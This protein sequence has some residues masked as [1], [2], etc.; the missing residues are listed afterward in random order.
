MGDKTVGNQVVGV[1][2]IPIQRSALED[3][4]EW[5]WFNQQ[6]RFFDLFGGLRSVLERYGNEELYAIANKDL[7]AFTSWYALTH[8]LEARHEV[9]DEGSVPDPVNST[10]EF[11]GEFVD[12]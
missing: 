10:P 8:R 4:C 12:L 9:Q 2:G 11:S 7:D 1:T 6:G 3:Y 5:L